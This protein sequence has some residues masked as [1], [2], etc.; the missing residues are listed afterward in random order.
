[1]YQQEM[2]SQGLFRDAKFLGAGTFGHVHDIGNGWV[3]KYA[4]VDGTLNYLEWC[5][6]KQAI[7]EHMLGMPV[8][9]SLV[10]FDTCTYMV[11]MRKYEKLRLGDFEYSTFR[12]YH[13]DHDYDLLTDAG[14][15]H[16]HLVELF[17]AY[18]DY[19][20]SSIGLER[21]NFD[22]HADNLMLDG[23]TVIA[24]DPCC[25]AYVC[26]DD[27]LSPPELVLQ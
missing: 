18:S 17:A 22:L 10:V 16:E 9:D 11:T 12:N 27:R 3:V 14:F 19:S 21:V 4:S 23:N 26:H 13:D 8:I 5:R 24:T 15:E 20:F 25:G 6:H 7:G 2:F 1:M